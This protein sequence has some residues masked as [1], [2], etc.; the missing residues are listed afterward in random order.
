MQR[1]CATRTRSTSAVG[2]GLWAFR[3]R[4]GPHM[5]SS[6]EAGGRRKAH[7]LYSFHLSKNDELQLLLEGLGGKQLACHCALDRPCH[8]DQ[9]IEAFKAR[10]C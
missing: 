5:V 6:L 8:G 7:K 1:M 3:A 9:I 2:I 10:F 4:F